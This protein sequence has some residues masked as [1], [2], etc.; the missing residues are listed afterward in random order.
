MATH[1]VSLQHLDADQRAAL[2]EDIQQR[3]EKFE[4]TVAEDNAAEC[5]H[6]SASLLGFSPLSESLVLELVPQVIAR[7]NGDDEED[8][9]ESA[10]V[11]VRVTV[12]AKVRLLA[13]SSVDDVLSEAD[14]AFTSRTA[15]ASIHSTEMTDVT[16]VRT[17]GALVTVNVEFSLSLRINDVAT[18][19]TQVMTEMDYQLSSSDPDAG[20]IEQ[21]EI[22]DF[23]VVPVFTRIPYLYRDADN[24]KAHG[25]IVLEGTLS[26]ADLECIKTALEDGEYFIPGDLSEFSIEELQSKLTSFPS[27]SDHVYHELELDELEQVKTIEEGTTTIP[28]AEFVRAFQRIG[29]GNGWNIVAAMQ[30]IGLM[31]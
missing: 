9:S 31:Y 13:A 30:R 16:E 27:D 11:D 1:Q 20:L 12:S 3:A 14:Y 21:T 10:S 25:Y 24:Y 18:S 5:L 23:E 17:D 2:L 19:P 6:E 29:T 28:A 26:A 7:C 15:G 8:H 4:F 22:R